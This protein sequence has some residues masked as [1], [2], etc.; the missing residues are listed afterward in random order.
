M[1]E[2]V[3]NCRDA[4]RA[5]GSAEEYV[6]CIFRE[7]LKREREEKLVMRGTWALVELSGR[8]GA[9]DYIPA[10]AIKEFAGI[11]GTGKGGR[12]A[13]GGLWPW[14]E[15]E[16]NVVEEQSVTKAYRIRREFYQAM[17]QLFDTPASTAS[18][19]IVELEG[20]GKEIWEDID[21]KEYIEQ[22]RKSWDG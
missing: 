18:H 16:A 10:N 11:R 3:R 14:L 22:E 17:Q 12:S 7:A 6:R 19:S 5:G 21:P 20:L 2:Y 13:S 15:R 9:N 8:R 4:Y 1:R